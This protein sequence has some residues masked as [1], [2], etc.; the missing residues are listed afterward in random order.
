MSERV[1]WESCPSCGDRAAVGWTGDAVT[2]FD[3]VRRCDLTHEQ[4]AEVRLWCGP[5]APSSAA[6]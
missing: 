4:M 3:C 1:T 6:R 2:E 5:P